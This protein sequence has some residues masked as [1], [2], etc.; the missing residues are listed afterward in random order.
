VNVR[1][2]SV[3]NLIDEAKNTWKIRPELYN[4]RERDLDG[5]FDRD[6]VRIGLKHWLS[7][8]MPYCSPTATVERIIMKGNSNCQMTISIALKHEEYLGV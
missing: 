1:D 3:M 7:C 6:T 2:T 8:I 4:S 5:D